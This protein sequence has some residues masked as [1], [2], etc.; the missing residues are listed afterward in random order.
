MLTS[1]AQQR[2]AAER[3]RNLAAAT[4]ATAAATATKH[5]VL[6]NTLQQQQQ[7]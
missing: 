1:L 6:W 7:Q 2:L 3:N 5:L 4:A